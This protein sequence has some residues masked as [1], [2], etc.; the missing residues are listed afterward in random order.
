MTVLLHPH[1]KDRLIERG[2]TEAEVKIT[3]STGEIF[4]AKFSRTGFRKNFYFGKMWKGKTYLTKQV[5]AFAVKE[6]EDWLVI[7]V[8]TKFF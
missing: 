2:V 1:A 3:V 6:H 7:T 4:P 8:V 5:E